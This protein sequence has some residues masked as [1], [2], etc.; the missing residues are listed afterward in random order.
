MNRKTVKSS[1]SANKPRKKSGSAADNVYSIIPFVLLVVSIIIESCLVFPNGTGAVGQAVQKIMCGVF[2][3]VSYLIPAGLLMLAFC[4][5]EIRRNRSMVIK[6]VT[7]SLFV[8]FFSACQS[9]AG[10]QQLADT[11][12]LSVLFENGVLGVGGGAVGGL[13]GKLMILAFD[14][15][16][17]IALSAVIA[18]IALSLFI[19]AKSIGV[20]HYV[21]AKLGVKLPKKQPKVK[22]EEPKT[23]PKAMPEKATVEPENDPVPVPKTAEPVKLETTVSEPEPIKPRD[24]S[25]YDPFV[26]GSALVSDAPGDAVQTAQPT[27][28]QYEQTPPQEQKQPERRPVPIG[29]NGKAR[30]YSPFAN[31]FYEEEVA[32]QPSRQPASQ[33]SNGSSYSPFADPFSSMNDTHSTGRTLPPQSYIA[34]DAEYKDKKATS[35]TQPTDPVE[36]AEDDEE[37]KSG[38]LKFLHRSDEASRQDD[39]DI[40]TSESPLRTAAPTPEPAATKHSEPRTAAPSTPSRKASPEP[41]KKEPPVITP[42]YYSPPFDIEDVE[43]EDYEDEDIEVDQ[44]VM[45]DTTPPTSNG[46]EIR[47]VYGSEPRYA[48]YVYP[49]FDLLDPP[50]PLNQISEEEVMAIRNTLLEKLA[51]FRVEAT[52]S[53][54]SVG[55]TITR[56]EITPGPGVK[57]R[58]ITALTEDLALALQSDG[59]RIAAVSGKSAIGVEVPNEKVSTVSL[60]ALIESR[61]FINAKSRIT[62]C[63]GLTVTG[64]PVYMDIDDMPHVLIAG[65]TKSGKSVAINCMILSLLYR[66]SPD[67]V[68]L[69]LIDPKRVELNVYSK[70]PHLVMPVIDNPK[71]AAAALRWAVNE[72]DRRYMLLDKMG[73]RNREEYCELRKQDPS[74]ELMPQIIIVIDE[75]ADLML[76]VREFVEEL[77]NRLAAMARACGMHLL[78]GTQRPSVDIITGLIKA[79]IP[80]RIAF[81]VSSGQDSQIILGGKGAEKLLGRGDMLYQATGAG[82]MRIQGAFVSGTEIK[83]LT[84]FLIEKNGPAEFDPEILR[85]LDCEVEKMNKSSK[86][87]SYT[88]DDEDNGTV[89][90]YEPDF[91]LLCRAI[92]YILETGKTSTNVIQR[93]LHVGFNRAADIIDTLEDMGFLST[94]DGNRPREV[95]VTWEM[96]EEWKMRKQL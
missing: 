48:D 69:I 27:T 10:D 61:E 81:K 80:A 7:L 75:L 72:M 31:P 63:V 82:R 39:D 8:L 54:Y 11:S 42:D 19:G 40:Y 21:F 95:Q 74:L 34:C 91:D 26:Y 57:V 33:K 96:Y 55:P 49:H 87:S 67:E 13:V 12:K 85:S 70:I 43:A 59:V 64:K 29:K 92:E 36:E 51:S 93:V 71:R 32:S 65:E 46:E 79:N 44:D 94:R 37:K 17:S 30:A 1:P 66:A 15:T 53:G 25:N 3:A 5:F 4:F 77:I 16:F 62:V 38:I 60:R 90:G 9:V 22:K 41:E 56:Y 83:R 52:L 20:W 47:Q 50:K 73:V 68:Q 84:A 86:K 28:P 18:I 35:V 76:Q 89:D 23:E 45:F 58:Q 24:L 6:I 78:V 14:K 2:G 88:D